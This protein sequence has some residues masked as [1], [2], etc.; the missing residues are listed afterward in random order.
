MWSIGVL[1]ARLR[2]LSVQ[3]ADACGLVV[4]VDALVV[5]RSDLFRELCCPVVAGA[6]LEA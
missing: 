6:V 1:R 2:R 5:L 3:L 4:R